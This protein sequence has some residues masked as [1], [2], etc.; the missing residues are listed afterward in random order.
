MLGE[1]VGEG[2]KLGP[3][4]VGDGRVDALGVAAVV[5]GS[6]RAGRFEPFADRGNPAKNVPDSSDE[7][8]KLRAEIEGSEGESKEGKDA[9]NETHYGEDLIRV[10]F[11]PGGQG[12][13]G[14]G[15]VE[16]GLVH[17]VLVELV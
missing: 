11:F 17:E 6:G 1:K 8:A 13:V 4:V 7:G 2:R 5:V 15:P 3:H 12:R 14:E 9:K 16:L 10:S